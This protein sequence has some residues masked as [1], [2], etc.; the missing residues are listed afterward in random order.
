MLVRYYVATSQLWLGD[1]TSYSRAERDATRS[2]AVYERPPAEKRRLGELCLARLDLAAARL[3]RRD[4]DGAAE[5]IEE[6]LS[7][8]AKRRI[9]SVARRLNQ[10]AIALDS[11]SYRRA[12]LGQGLRGQIGTYLRSPTLA[13]PSGSCL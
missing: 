6:V 7:V 8:G 4:L 13:L 12:S 3:A 10:V 5:Q 9:E 1:A 2:I 11:G